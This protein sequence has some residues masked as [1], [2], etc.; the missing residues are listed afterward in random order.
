MKFTTRDIG[1][2]I[3]AVGL[4][5]GWYLDRCAT[6]NAFDALIRNRHNFKWIGGGVPYWGHQVGRSPDDQIDFLDEVWTKTQ[7]VKWNV[8]S[9]EGR[10]I[11]ESAEFSGVIVYGDTEQ[12]ARERAEVMAELLFRNPGFTDGLFIKN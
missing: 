8:E 7:A 11:A 10:W 12:E 1:W 3:L 5:L 6:I 9:R 4:V 2:S